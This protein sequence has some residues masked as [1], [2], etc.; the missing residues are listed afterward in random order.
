MCYRL[1]TALT[2]RFPD[3]GSFPQSV[4]LRVGTGDFSAINH[5]GSETQYSHQH[6]HYQSS[7]INQPSVP[8]QC[9]ALR[10][11]THLDIH[12]TKLRHSGL[13]GV[14]DGL[15][16]YTTIS[17]LSCNSADSVSGRGGVCRV[18][19]QRCSGRRARRP[20]FVPLR[21]VAVSLGKRRCGD[22]SKAIL[23]LQSTKGSSVV[24]LRG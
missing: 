5:I 2:S 8:R 18:S 24:F 20:P 11:R 23:R 12:A 16:P 21:H 15:G 6:L 22:T 19:D 10:K 4:H 13:K 17:L 3:S 1:S 14:W 7:I 9:S